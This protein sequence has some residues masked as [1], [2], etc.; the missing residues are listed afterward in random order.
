MSLILDALDKADRER[1]S[2][3][4]ADEIPPQDISEQAESEHRRSVTYF[5]AGAVILVLLAAATLYWNYREQ[6]AASAS[7]TLANTTAPEQPRAEIEKPAPAKATVEAAQAP[8]GKQPVPAVAPAELAQSVARPVL[9][10]QPAA[11]DD[12]T[13]ARAAR[14]VSAATVQ[15]AIAAQYNNARPSQQMSPEGSAEKAQQVAALYTKATPTPA[16]KTETPPVAATAASLSSAAPAPKESA[17]ANSEPTLANFTE[18]GSIRSLPWTVQQKIPTLN[19]S[20]HN[21]QS[22]QDASVVINGTTRRRGDSLEQGLVLEMILRD[23]IILKY[24]GQAFKVPALNSW[25]NM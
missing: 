24:Q 9:K 8:A 3:L 1:Q 21:Y 12:N 6:P 13:A 7:T 22:L 19:Y 4:A 25:V 18:L 23:G 11:T 5:A 10:K 16:P 2:K 14:D 15:K 20:A 17:P